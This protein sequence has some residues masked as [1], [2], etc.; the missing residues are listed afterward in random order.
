M[1]TIHAKQLIPLIKT[2]FPGFSPFWEKFESYWGSDQ[3][4]TI[5][6]IPFSEYALSVINRHDDKT[7]KEIF[8]FV[9]KLLVHGDESV[10]NAIATSFLEHLLSQDAEEIDFKKITKFFGKQTMGYCK[11]WDQFTGVKTPGIGDTET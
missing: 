9:E 10:K 3:G 8:D 7:I 5:E 6:L 4:L 11:A 2:K 1:K